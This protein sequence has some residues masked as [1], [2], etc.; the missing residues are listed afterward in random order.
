MTVSP[1]YAY[2]SPED[3][4]E[5]ERVSPIKHEYIRGEVYAMAGASKA[6]VTIAGN[7]FAMLRSHL[8]GR[9]CIP[10]MADMKVQIEAASIYYYPDVT[11]TCDERDNSSS[12]EDFIRYPCLVVEVLSPKTAAFDRGDKF[13]DYRTIDTLED[14]VLINQERMSVECFRRNSEGLWVLHPYSQGEEIYLASVDFHCPIEALYE[15]V[16]GL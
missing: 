11:V 13:A 14:Y 12:D 8:R 9:G 10:Y 16:M 6:H 3:Y 4:L 15:D 2:I 1:N 5:G 7:L